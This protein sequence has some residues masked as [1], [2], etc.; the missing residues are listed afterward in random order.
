M[1]YLMMTEET[2]QLANYLLLS[3]SF[4]SHTYT[5]THSQNQN[6]ILTSL[7]YSGFFLQI[8]SWKLPIKPFYSFSWFHRLRR[9]FPLHPKAHTN[10]IPAPWWCQ[11]SDMMKIRDKTPRHMRC[12][13]TE[14][15]GR[16]FAVIH[17]M[18]RIARIIV[19]CVASGGTSRLTFWQISA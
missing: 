19:P 6:A 4:H 8:F 1:F 14:T 5:H 10:H 2:Y 3:L 17:L 12:S 11:D 15:S 7:I 16:S 9:A 18:F 13:W